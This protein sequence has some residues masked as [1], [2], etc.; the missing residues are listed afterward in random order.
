MHNRDHGGPGPAHRRPS[1]RRG[2]RVPA[3][4]HRGGDDLARPDR[5]GR[6]RLRGLRPLRPRR[7][8]VPAESRTGHPEPDRRHG[9]RLVRFVRGADLRQRRGDRH[10][11]HRRGGR[12]APQ[13]PVRANRRR[14]DGV[15]QRPEQPD[16]GVSGSEPEREE[17][18][19][20]RRMAAAERALL[21][22]P[23]GGVREADARPDRRRG[24]TRRA[25]ARARRVRIRA[26]AR[27]GR[28][29][30][31][32]ERYGSRRSPSRADLP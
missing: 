19:G 7:L 3:A 15:R 17:R 23:H 24:R 28:R 26:G 9:G 18:Q 2:R 31:H 25:G 16:A 29:V 20:R 6:G 14:K 4:G 1:Y 10:R 11:A 27:P 5:A 21:V 30:G 12:G 8:R 32:H 22:R 13:R